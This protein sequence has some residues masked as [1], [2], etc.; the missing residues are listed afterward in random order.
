MLFLI[1]LYFIVSN[2]VRRYEG[3]ERLPR[4]S[5]TSYG[6]VVGVAG[7]KTPQNSSLEPACN[8]YLASVFAAAEYCKLVIYIYL[9]L[10]I[11]S[12]PSSA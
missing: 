6:S 1:K 2:S 4:Y 9:Y 3:Q 7:Q 8:I 5:T 11:F 10:F 12:H